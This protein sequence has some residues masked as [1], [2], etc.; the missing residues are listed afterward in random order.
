MLLLF[1]GRL[2]YY[3]VSKSTVLTVLYAI[4]KTLTVVAIS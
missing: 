1:I 3:F 2:R 4:Q